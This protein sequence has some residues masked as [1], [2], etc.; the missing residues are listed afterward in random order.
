MADTAGYYLTG[1][2]YSRALAG[3]VVALI[4]MLLLTPVCGWLFHCGCSWPWAGLDSGCNFYIEQAPEKCPW[5]KSL[6][7]GIASAGLSIAAG[8][9]TAVR[10]PTGAR[11]P[12]GSLPRP[13][14]LPGDLLLRIFTG[15]AV[16]L[17]LAVLTGW[18]SAAWQGYSYFVFTV[19]GQAYSAMQIS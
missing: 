10:L 8:I 9:W 3:I 14:S 11:V 16:F 4:T 17:L 7:A 6:F 1:S 13:G 2:K 18:M 12:G 19:G 15:T 5:C